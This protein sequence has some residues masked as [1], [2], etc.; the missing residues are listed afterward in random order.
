L[1]TIDTF[2]KVN[3]NAARQRAAFLSTA[4]SFSVE[5]AGAFKAPECPA[6]SENGFSRGAVDISELER[7]A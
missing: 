4:G 5:G 2:F 3:E 1:K 6:R 7:A